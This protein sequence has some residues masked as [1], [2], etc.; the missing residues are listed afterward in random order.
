MII[1]GID[2][3]TRVTGYAVIQFSNDQ[4]LSAFKILEF[5]SWNLMTKK[6]DNHLG[7]RLEKL[8]DLNSELFKKWNPHLIALEKAITFKNVQSALKLSEARGVIRLAACK[9]LQKAN[10]RL[11]EMSPT[12]IKKNSAGLGGA[13][14]SDISRVLKLRFSQDLEVSETGKKTDDAYDAVAIA[15]SGWVQHKKLTLAKPTV[16]DYGIVKGNGK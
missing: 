4:G 16:Q 2:P 11:I 5:G 1:V 15:W 10:E 7:E 12:N 8:Y 3:G 13:K 14:K 9:T 6:S